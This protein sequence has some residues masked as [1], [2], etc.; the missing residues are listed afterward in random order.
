VALINNIV[1]SL[2]FGKKSILDTVSMDTKPGNLT[3]IDGGITI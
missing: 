3:F 1:H 2:I